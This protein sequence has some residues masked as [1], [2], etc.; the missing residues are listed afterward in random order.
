MR[1]SPM[2]MHAHKGARAVNDTVGQLVYYAPS[3]PAWR[4][5]LLACSPGWCATM[6]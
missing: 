3:S 2:H 6:E 4:P 5:L 1:T